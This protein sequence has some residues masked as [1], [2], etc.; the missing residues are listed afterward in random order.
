MLTIP[1][2]TIYQMMIL[3][4]KNINT[5]N[6]HWGSCACVDN[7]ARWKTE[8]PQRRSDEGGTRHHEWAHALVGSD[9][10]CLG[11][12]L[13]KHFPSVMFGS[14]KC[15]ALWPERWAVCVR[16]RICLHPDLKQNFLFVFVGFRPYQWFVCY[17]PID[18]ENSVVQVHLN[19]SRFGCVLI[20]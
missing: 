3:G 18:S 8:R 7:M 11:F 14:K 9:W 4:N 10:R 5:E 19:K 20:L 12:F 13:V 6:N 16:H 1:K 15:P 17:F 2:V